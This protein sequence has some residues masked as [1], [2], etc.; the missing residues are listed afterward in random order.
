MEER[1]DEQTALSE[2]PADGDLIHVVDVSDT[3]DNAAGSSKKI[4]RANFL[5]RVDDET[6]SGTIDGSNDTFTLAFTPRN[7]TSIK[8]YRNRLLQLQGIDYDPSGIS[9][10]F[11]AGKLPR[12][13]NTLRVDYEK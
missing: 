3:T 7:T 8:L 12:T 10:V 5:G 2:T 6:P 1:L 4:T 9:M 13:G 11:K